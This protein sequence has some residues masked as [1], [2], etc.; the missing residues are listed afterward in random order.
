MPRIRRAY[1]SPFNSLINSN[2]GVL[3]LK[4]STNTFLNTD[5]LVS[6]KIDPRQKSNMAARLFKQF[7]NMNRSTFH[8]FGIK[9]RHDFNGEDFKLNINSSINIGSAPL[10]SP[11]TNK[12]DFSLI[13]KPR[14]EWNGIGPLLSQ[15]G[16]AVL[17][18]ILNLPQLKISEKRIPSWVL[19]SIILYRLG[20]MVNDLN[21]R[22]EYTENDLISP[23]G[24]VNWNT[25][26]N[27]R[28]P[29]TKFLSIPC[30]FP[31]LRN[32]RKIKSAIHYALLKQLKSLTTQR[33]SGYFVLQLIDLCNI[34][35]QKVSDTPPEKPSSEMFLFLYKYQLKN[36]TYKEGINAIDWTVNE[37]GLSGLGDFNG[38]PWMMSMDSLFEAF[39]ESICIKLKNEIGGTLR[40]GR[41]R[42]TIIPINWQPN[43]LG[44][45]KFLLPDIIIEKEDSVFIF[46]AKYK[47]HWEDMNVEKW[48][49]IEEEIRNRH[50]ND[51]L[52]ILAYSTLF[53]RTNINCCLV[54]PCRSETFMSLNVR[55]RQSHNA[56]I[57][58]DGRIINLKLTAL[59]LNVKLNDAVRLFKNII[60][61][62]K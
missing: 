47:D 38:I 62:R 58:N 29:K 28:I 53:K 55:G 24:K 59:P 15:T 25:Y 50:R 16:W 26:A 4:D 3:E 31:D 14:Y 39:I 9:L 48:Y 41:K 57:H 37:K 32:D 40:S 33:D 19:S 10:L 23:K 30:R 46:D 5:F 12:H 6:K 56:I 36:I 1:K 35:I 44:S 43:Y 27:D 52:Q 7:E 42:D 22:F 2:E 17:P 21:R 60:L 49:N 8:F 18:K 54:Y 11:I 45:Q 13:V 20:K 61:T 34:L 51:L